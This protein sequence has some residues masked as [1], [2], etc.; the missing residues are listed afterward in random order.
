V[1][2]NKPER[3]FFFCRFQGQ[4][5]VNRQT[6]CQTMINVSFILIHSHPHTPLPPRL[7][8]PLFSDTGSCYLY[9]CTHDIIFIPGRSFTDLGSLS[10]E[11]PRCMGLFQSW[12]FE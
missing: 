9:L 4:N 3:P 6:P 1:L 10:E 7:Q 2:P 5:G 12:C 8:T 11:T